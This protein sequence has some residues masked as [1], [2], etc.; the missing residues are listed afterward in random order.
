MGPGVSFR[1]DLSEDYR[2]KERDR[3]V[4]TGVGWKGGGGKEWKKGRRGGREDGSCTRSRWLEN[5]R[6]Y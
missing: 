6:S 2:N 5:S 3:K 1:N 4:D